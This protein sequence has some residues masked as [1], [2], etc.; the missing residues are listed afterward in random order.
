MTRSPACLTFRRAEG[1]LEIAWEPGGPATRLTARALRLAC[2]CAGCVDEF[3]GAALLDPA[4]VPADVSIAGAAPIGNY[5]VKFFFTDG[6]DTGLYTWDHL[7]S[8]PPG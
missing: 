3:T 8:L 4:S 7:A 6:H 1:V 5:A 2:R